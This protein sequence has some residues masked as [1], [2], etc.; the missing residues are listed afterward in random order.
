[1][2]CLWYLIMV[3][4]ANF[5]TPKLVC[6]HMVSL[7]PSGTK[8]VLEPT[9]GK[10]NLVGALANYDVTA[11]EN[12]WEWSGNWDC[13][14]MNPPF[15]PMSEGYKILYRCMKMST[16]IIAL[17]PWLTLINSEKRT[18][19]IVSFGLRSITH[20]PRSTFAGSRVQTCI[21]EMSLGYGGITE[22]SYF[23]PTKLKESYVR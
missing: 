1:M 12:F 9:P 3:D 14:V 23:P 13:I 7:I 11:P 22:W 5:Q 6:D 18:Q 4:N 19:D 16:N 21:L 20:L 8:T 2:I 17:M 15:S 10:G